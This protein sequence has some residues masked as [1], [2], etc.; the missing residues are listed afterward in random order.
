MA[1][2]LACG[3][4]V[5]GPVA[6]PKGATASARATASASASASVTAAP[7]PRSR[8]AGSRFTASAD[9]PLPPGSVAR[10]GTTAMR[11]PAPATVAVSD[12]GTI[13]AFRDGQLSDVRKGEVLAKL[14]G[15]QRT[16]FSPDARKLV[17]L[18]EG[19]VVELFEVPSGKSLGTSK[20]ELKPSEKPSKGIFNDLSDLPESVLNLAFS[21]DGQRIVVS[22]NQG[23][24][25]VLDGAR[26]KR[27]KTHKIEGASLGGVSRDGA[28]AL[29]LL[30]EPGVERTMLLG[31][32]GGLVGIKVIDLQSGAKLFSQAYEF[33]QDATTGAR[34][35]AHRQAA[36]GLSLDGTKVYRDERGELTAI[37][38]KSGKGQALGKSNEPNDV[39]NSFL[40]G[41]LGVLRM[42]PDGKR[43][44]SQGRL[45][46][47]RDGSRQDSR[48]F[49][50][51]S[52]SGEHTLRREGAVLS[53]GAE[54]IVGH[55]Q[56]VGALAFSAD[57]ET[58]I[59]ADGKLH[60][61]ETASCSERAP[62]EQRATNF[63][64]ARDQ[65]VLVIDGFPSQLIRGK[66]GTVT[67]LKQAVDARSLAL[68]ADGK[69]LF[70]GNGQGEETV[71][72]V[73]DVESQSPIVS[74]TIGGRLDG[75]ALSNDDNKLALNV[76]KNGRNELQLRNSRTLDLEAAFQEPADQLLFLGNDRLLLW[77]QYRALRELDLTTK[78]PGFQL[79]AGYCEAVA[80]SADQRWLAAGSDN[81]VLVW[82]LQAAAGAVKPRFL[83]Q[84]SGHK[85]RVRS[86]AFSSDG[87]LA[88]GS[89]D[90]TVLLW[91]LETVTK[92]PVSSHVAQT[93]EGPIT[94]A[95]WSSGDYRASAYIK[96]DGSI[97]WRG[98]AKY[99]ALSGVI[100]LATNY[101]ANCAVTSQG[102]V[103]CWGSTAGGVLGVPERPGKKPREIARIEK[104]LELPNVR[105][106]LRVEL[107]R[108][109]GCALHDGNRLTCWG[110]L[111][112]GP[113]SPPS[114]R[115]KDVVQFGLQGERACALTQQ[116]DLLCWSSSD[117]APPTKLASGVRSF[118][119]GATHLCVLGQDGNVSCLGEGAQLGEGTADKRKTLARLDRLSN[120]SELAAG[121]SGTC[122][123]AKPEG[124]PEGVYCWGAFTHA[125]HLV[126]TLMRGLEGTSGLLL[127][128]DRVCAARGGKRVC[129]ER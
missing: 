115:L 95:R 85:E 116:A 46:E 59:T 96:D 72:S 33:E 84:L 93:N 22:T 119:L 121:S 100:S 57:G 54:A 44:L 25:H 82:E 106:A 118:A 123:R 12:E 90:T 51:Q 58:L 53:V 87:T 105:N 128:G 79:G 4:S 23:A 77:D 19:N 26:A 80:L 125:T 97:A 102:A 56:G 9:E 45:I 27:L 107:A 40:L 67:P 7:A 117:A 62:T 52:L 127:L 42:L 65:P 31:G 73:R 16:V 32:S 69:R 29:L 35:R 109:Y 43:A 103:Q 13:Y 89:A 104:P 124:A 34:Q 68:S 5:E 21:L 55:S 1:L 15:L 8:I 14:P 66:Q 126:P 37:E 3:G 78:K 48:G 75:L 99:P 92:Q 101:H 11:V 113:I 110:R 61:W 74:Q 83:A 88:S 76:Q 120:V 91:D 111:G 71:L 20:L 28:R 6:Q 49:E 108:D 114:E 38:L 81:D 94:A 18:R 129:L 36:H 47:L 41:Q 64:M 50:F 10:C 60:R 2:L 70:A 98:L 122:A 24:L 39:V 63:R 30:S 17:G 86:L 112:V